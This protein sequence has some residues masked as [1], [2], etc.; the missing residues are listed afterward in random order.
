[1]PRIEYDFAKWDLRPQSTLDLDLLVITLNENPNI[2]IELNSHTDFRG[3][4]AQ[5][6]ILSQKRAD[7]CIQ[8][9]ISKGIAADRL[10]A[11]GKGESEPYIL[12][13]EDSEHD[14]RGGFFRKKIF[15]EGDVLTESYINKSKAKF[16]DIAHQ[17]NRRTA[18][19]VLTEDYIPSEEK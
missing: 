15:K 14:Q 7:A 3:T 9:L 10:V 18:F 16:K 17:Y 5:N 4:S 6:V 1:M 12:T 11:N 19:K 13:K 8:Y 2:T